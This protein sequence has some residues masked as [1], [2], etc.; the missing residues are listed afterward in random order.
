MNKDKIIELF[1]D[2]AVF[3]IRENKLY[4]PSFRKGFRKIS[5]TNVSLV[6]AE[7]ALGGL[8]TINNGVMRLV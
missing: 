4:H 7:N 3:N 5:S 6:A 2:G 1:K 8:L